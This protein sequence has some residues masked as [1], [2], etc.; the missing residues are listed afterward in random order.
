MP[1]FAQSYK[2]KETANEKAMK[3][4]RTA[5]TEIRQ[6]NERAALKSL[7]KSLKQ[8]PSFIDAQIEMGGVYYRLGELGKAAPILEKAVAKAPEHNIPLLFTL[9]A[10]KYDMDD[11]AQAAYYLN[12]YL[13]NP[14]RDSAVAQ[15][16]ER[17]LANSV[18]A[19]E[20]IKRPVPFEPKSMGNNINTY[21]SESLPNI[22]ADG[23]TLIYTVRLGGNEDFFVS[24]MANGEWSRGENMGSPINTTENEGA[25]TVAADGRTIIFTACNRQA[26][27]YGS[28]DLYMTQVV[29]GRWGVPVNLGS[30]INTKSWESLPSLS[31]DGQYLY[32]SSDRP[33]GL[34]GR[35][36]WV[37]QKQP[38]GQWG[39]PE[40]L[41]APIN[42]PNEEQ[43]PFIHAD[44]QTLY[45]MSTGHPGM[46]GYDLFFARRAANGQWGDPENLGYPINTKSNEGSLFISLDGKTA[47][48]A[49]DRQEKGSGSAFDKNDL[50]RNSDLYYFELY[51]KARPQPVTYVKAIVRDAVGGTPLQAKVSFVNLRTG[52]PH[53]TAT[54]D[55]NGSFL[56][57][58]PLGQNYALNVSK[59]KYLFHSENFEL[60]EVRSQEKPFLLDIGLQ[61]LPAAVATTKPATSQP[62]GPSSNLPQPTSK[63][64]V[65][66]NIFFEFGK[67]TL[68]PESV[69][70]LESLRLLLVEN[71]YMNIQING[72]TD[73]VGSDADNLRLS[74]DRARAVRDYL[75]QHGIAATRLRYKGFGE[76]RPIGTNET[77]E[78]RQQ[79]RR[80]EFELF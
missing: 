77:D 8:E 18:F 2:T 66:K 71:P 61:P 27:G 56:V 31:A 15:K 69:T 63:P 72:H 17:L 5:I 29:G 54:T 22:T 46:G 59:E 10:M 12:R 24:K 30:N 51:E 6:G 70:E 1:A 20:A 21:G 58:L 68:R 79:N 52:Q 43:A 39:K 50:S 75:V 49:S 14:K 78:G 40:N 65:L 64:I 37:S 16:A 62:S 3:S 23:S 9:G 45:F 55:E 26:D 53:A 32:F 67:A 13:A 44:G 42:T 76:S 48:Y 4:Y 28:C 33:G 41:G 25:H 57:C 19:K 34:G 35:D 47:Y 38:N 11:F 7:E 60:S 80:T 74:D 36:I 73:N